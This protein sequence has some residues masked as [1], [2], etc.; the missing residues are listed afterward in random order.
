MKDI[1]Y[2]VILKT[3]KTVENIYFKDDK[4]YPPFSTGIQAEIDNPRAT[5]VL[6]VIY[7]IPKLSKKPTEPVDPGEPKDP[8]SP[9]EPETPPGPAGEP[10]DP[11][12]PVDEIKPSA[13]RKR[14]R[15]KNNLKGF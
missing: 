15:K 13:R 8:E 11:G 7:E 10:V 5:P 4:V 2:C 6:K 3:L 1:S 9:K 14:P 12:E